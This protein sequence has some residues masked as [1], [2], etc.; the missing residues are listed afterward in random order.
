MMNSN[1]ISNYDESVYYAKELAESMA[2]RRTEILYKTTLS[3][4]DL[5][6]MV[7]FFGDFPI[8]QGEKERLNPRHELNM[9]ERDGK[10]NR[11]LFSYTPEQINRHLSDPMVSGYY[12]ALFDEMYGFRLDQAPAYF[13]QLLLADH[14]IDFVDARN[15]SSYFW[16]SWIE[17]GETGILNGLKGSGKNAFALWIA[18]MAM[19]ENRNLRLATNTI[20]R[21]EEFAYDHFT[22][23]GEWMYIIFKNASEGYFTLSEL[24]ELTVA[25]IRKKQTMAKST[26]TLD[27]IDRGTRKA[28][29]SNLYVWH[30]ESEV[31]KEFW[32]AA[33]FK[34]YKF[35]SKKN[36]QE[37][38][39]GRFIFKDDLKENVYHIRGIPDSP[40]KFLSEDFPTFVLDIDL[41]S[42]MAMWSKEEHRQ[43]EKKEM[44][45]KLAD[46]VRIQVDKARDIPLLDL[47]DDGWK[48]MDEAVIY[49]GLNK[50]QIM[51][52]N[53]LYKTI[54]EDGKMY[55][56]PS[57]GH[58]WNGEVIES[59]ID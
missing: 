33:N 59:G 38:V 3:Y 2:K 28:D 49:S 42:V 57:E 23:I 53:L 17:G 15:F 31:P 50:K 22:T 11:P 14:R 55:V 34:G 5:I 13:R 44:F 58:N 56:K 1:Q 46:V 39:K 19:T 26:L 4:D 32:S 25:G 29:D 12:K 21:E 51:S 8:K 18:Q 27:A 16:T 41:P 40:I 36:W 45:A 35:G 47:V 48:V 43:D 20:I 30:Y 24:D 6:W 37:R 7:N 9:L 10:G 54:G 52:T